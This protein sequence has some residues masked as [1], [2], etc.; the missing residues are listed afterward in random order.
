M[1]E[2]GRGSSAFNPSP[3]KGFHACTLEKSSGSMTAYRA[4]TK[5]DVQRIKLFLKEN[6]L[7]V[8]GVDEWVEHFLILTNQEGKWIGVAGFEL[9]GDSCLLRSVAVDQSFRGRGFGKGLVDAVLVNANRKGAS[10][11]YL[12]TADAEIYFNKMGFEIIRREDV[13]EAVLASAEFK[14]NA[15]ERCTVMLKRIY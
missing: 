5:S 11:S 8:D 9:Y 2:I 13:E 1:I 6:E 10:K 14:I 12:L 4:A 15:C 3:T 7:S